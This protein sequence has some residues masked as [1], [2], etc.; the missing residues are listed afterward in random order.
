M[1]RVPLALVFALAG[2]CASAAAAGSHVSP[3]DRLFDA[4]PPEIR[5]TCTQ[6]DPSPKRLAGIAELRCRGRNR[7]GVSYVLYKTEQAMSDA[8]LRA[9]AADGIKRNQGLGCRKQSSEGSFAVGK[10]TVGRYFC[11]TKT[12]TVQWYD[13]R[14]LVGARATARTGG[15]GQTKDV[16]AWWACCAGPVTP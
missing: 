9:R 13:K 5:G 11:A 14:V 16:F 3:V 1:R 15:L 6:V 4:V 10:K 12:A 2:A 7:I 8:Y